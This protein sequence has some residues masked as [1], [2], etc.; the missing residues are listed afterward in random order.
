MVASRD[1]GRIAPHGRRLDLLLGFG[2][3]LCLIPFLLLAWATAVGPPANDLSVTHPAPDTWVVASVPIGGPAWSTGVRPGMEVI[4]AEPAGTDPS[5][6]WDSLLV[7]DGGIRISLPRQQLTPSDGPTAVA[8]V[9]LL[10]AA[11]AALRLPNLA[12]LLALTSVSVSTLGVSTLFDPPASLG[13]LLAGP[14]GAAIFAADRRRR[15]HDRLVVPVAAVAALVPAVWVAAY[16]VRPDNWRQLSELSVLATAVLA[17]VGIGG[18]AA[19]A[20]DRARRRLPAGRLSAGTIMGALADEL[21]P[22]RALTRISAI[23]RERAELATE[24]HADVLPHLSTAIREVEAGTPRE[25]AA[26]RL[27]TVAAELRDLMHERRLV[28]LDE[29]GLTSALEWLAE[30]IEERSELIVEVDV[31]GSDNNAPASRPPRDVELAA[32]RIAQQAL[33][34]AL[35]HARPNAIRVQICADASHVAL[36]VADDGIG[37]AP[38]ALER[39]LREGHLGLSDMRERADAI[40]AELSVTSSPTGG[41]RVALR[42]PA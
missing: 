21:V 39:A 10:L 1:I 4:G 18:V 3:V 15:V 36:E 32:Y 12:W 20:W 34:N 22:G 40:G 38:G 41:T 25:E 26:R 24:L 9:L 31:M 28:L 23:E 37:I 35:L 7:T 16:L 19:H 14:I 6:S 27:R 29:L 2:L 13:V 5:V 17:C 8:G 33:D 11:L 30:R 42:W